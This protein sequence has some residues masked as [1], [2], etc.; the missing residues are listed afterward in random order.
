MEKKTKTLIN[1]IT[2]PDTFLFF[3]LFF[4]SGVLFLGLF[5]LGFLLKYHSLASGIPLSILFQSFI[6]GARFDMVVLTYLLTPFFI[7]SSFPRIGFFRLKWGRKIV[8]PW[9]FYP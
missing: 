3:A 1:S 2:P 6:I 9:S 7:L 4:F 5:R 8:L